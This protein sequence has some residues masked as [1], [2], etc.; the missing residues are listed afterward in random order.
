MIKP[1]RAAFVSDEWASLVIPPPYDSLSTVEREQ[2]LLDHPKSFLH[3]TRSADASH[4]HPTEHQRLAEEGR[5]ALEMLMSDEVYISQPSSSLFLQ[6]IESDGITQRAIIGAI[7]IAEVAPRPHE[8]VHPGRVQALA[9]HFRHVGSMSSPVV[10]TTRK[11]HLNLPSLEDSDRVELVSRFL[12]IDGT[13]ISVWT[14][15]LED[16]GDVDGLYI[17]DG[18]HRIA[19]AREAGFSQLLVAYVPPSELRM[20]SFDRDVDE[21]EFLPR[22]TI[23]RLSEWCDVRESSES[24]ATQPA[25]KGVIK[26]RFGNDWFWAKRRNIEG[27]DSEFVHTTLL[28]E[29]FGIYDADDPRLSYR[30]V[31]SKRPDSSATVRLAPADLEDVF[32]TADAGRTMPPKT[33]YFFPKARSGVLIIEC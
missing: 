12:A 17:V 4:G 24:E 23:D 5:E 9:T 15:A 2:H 10:L 28:P 32:S 7:D 29:L 3:V 8:A 20:S 18:H 19:A 22:K 25:A 16:F 21:L 14:V 6:K 27:L 33:T 31:G 13:K 1:I 30:P 11:D 26:L